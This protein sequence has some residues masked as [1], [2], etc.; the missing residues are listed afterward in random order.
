MF[1]VIRLALWASLLAIVL[2]GSLA[3]AS[4]SP[5]DRAA[6][7]G[8]WDVVAVV[9]SGRPVDPKIA[10]MLQVAYREDGSWTVLFKGLA[11]GEGTSVNDAE[12]SP[13]TF[14]MQTLGGTKTPPRKY[15]GIYRLEGDTR[16]LC[17]VIAGQPR[18]DDFTSPRG[19]GRILVKLKRAEEQ[20]AQQ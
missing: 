1:A 3:R 6:S 4:S 2:A 18:P 15:S 13:K 12:T 17:F 19:S 14:E 10:S 11:V 8:S 9:M 5:D 20:G 16:Q 7:A